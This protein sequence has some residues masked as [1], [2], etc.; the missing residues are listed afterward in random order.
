MHVLPWKMVLVLC[1]LWNDAC[2]HSIA[3]PALLSSYAQTP[4]ARSQILRSNWR[5]KTV[6]VATRDGD[7]LCGYNVVCILQRLEYQYSC[8]QCAC[9]KLRVWAR[10]GAVS[11]RACAC[12]PICLFWRPW[13]MVL[14]THKLLSLL[15][16]TQTY[17]RLSFSILNLSPI[18]Q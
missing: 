11:V 13:S 15:P 17:P 2:L 8:I 3:L 7:N 9:V 18:L 6:C 4:D 5:S 12:V 1:T 16:K 14:R 10:S